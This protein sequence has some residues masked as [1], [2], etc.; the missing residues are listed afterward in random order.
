MDNLARDAFL[1]RK[2]GMSYGKWKAMQPIAPKKEKVIPEGWRKCKGCGI[3]FK[4]NRGNH[5]YCEIE[6]RARDWARKHKEV[7]QVYYEKYREKHIEYM[8]DYRRRKKEENAD[9]KD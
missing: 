6:C 3:A 1:A 9:G 8:R 2:A 7:H 5:V 4:P